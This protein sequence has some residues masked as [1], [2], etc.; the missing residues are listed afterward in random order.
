MY[1]EMNK[2]NLKIKKNENGKWKIR[3]KERGNQIETKEREE[4]KRK[5]V[6]KETQKKKEE[7]KK[8]M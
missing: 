2:R 8:I 3:T 6:T 4:Q 7:G 1:Q 5:K